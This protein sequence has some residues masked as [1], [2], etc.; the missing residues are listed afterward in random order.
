[1][2]EIRFHGRGGQGAV[3]ASEILATAL[4]YEGKSVQAFPA[5]GVE[6]R[7]APV[8]AFL[9]SDRQPIRQRCQVYN[10][11]YVIV[12]DPTLISVIDVTAGLNEQGTIVINSDRP[13]EFF[14]RLNRF[15]VITVPAG[16]I[17]AAHGLGTRTNPIA[18][19]AI[20]GAIARTG[21]VDLDAIEKAIV[22]K[23]PSRAEENIAAAREAYDR[24]VMAPAGALSNNARVTT[25]RGRVSP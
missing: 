14:A 23:M 3:L 7:G 19:T 13:P 22:E 5:F 4:F 2:I 24:L 16:A 10:P 15:S 9:R 1:M 17:A 20:L 6:R 18:N 8:T 21:L 12:L 11:D 25:N